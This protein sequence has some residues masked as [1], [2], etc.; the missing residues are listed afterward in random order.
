MLIEDEL[1]PKLVVE[2]RI[3]GAHVK[4]ARR[5][6]HL[7]SGRGAD[8]LSGAYRGSCRL[9]SGFG[10]PGRETPP[11]TAQMPLYGDFSI[12]GA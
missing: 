9:V 4:L 1:L 7:G 10:R 2:P 8:G 3:D 5:R 11:K 6:R 12:E